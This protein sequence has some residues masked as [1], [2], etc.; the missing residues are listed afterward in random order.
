VKFIKKI[1]SIILICVITLFGC[2]FN[3]TNDV[4]SE[5]L[6]EV[7]D[8]PEDEKGDPEE[9]VYKPE[10]DSLEDE[11]LLDYVKDNVYLEVVKSLNSED[12]YVE[13]VDTVYVSKEYLEELSYNAQANIF[14]G[15]T[16]EEIE[17]VYGDAKYVFTV[18]DDGNTIV[19]PFEDYDDTFEQIIANVAIGTGVILVCVT[20][21]VV[22]ASAGAPAVSLIFATSAKTGTGMALSS[23]ILGG[24]TSGLITGIET[25]DMSEALK[26][27]ALAGSDGFKW[28]AITGTIIGGTSGTVKYSQAMK[29]LEGA[30]LHIPLQEAAKIQMETG[31]PAEIISEFHSKEE[32]QVFNKAGLKATMV[33]GKSALV[34]T[35]ID[36]SLVDEYGRTN[37]Q[38]MKLGLSPLDS[39]GNYYELHHIGQEAEGTLAILTQSEHDNSVL[40][41]FK[42]ISEIDRDAFAVQRRNFWKTMAK[43]LESGG[44]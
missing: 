33:N 3:Q 25:G 31:Y 34:R 32:Y 26:S 28:G 5:A 7:A 23:G 6:D 21:S 2:S 27:G 38:R 13:N 1:I 30:E 37:L 41:G 40:H 16:I 20:V 44:I 11:A 8:I 9:Y 35:D 43:M 15:Y 36:L 42:A 12:Y 24:I 29:A 4:T 18:D 14:F 39:A 17:E 22:T 10:F 19:K